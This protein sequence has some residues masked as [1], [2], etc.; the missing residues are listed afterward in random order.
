MVT[1]EITA[2]IQ[3][4]AGH[5]AAEAIQ[6][7][8]ESAQKNSNHGAV[9]TAISILTLLLSASGVFSELRTVLNK[10][11]DVKQDQNSGIVTLVREE[12][13]SFGMVLAVGFLL[14]ASLMISATLAAA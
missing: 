12:I 9:A 5:G 1:R 7:A 10:I 11:W 4:L 13:F 14:L 6:A 2:Q 3:I 8:L